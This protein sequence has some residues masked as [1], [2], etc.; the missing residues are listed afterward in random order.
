MAKSFHRNKWAALKRLA[1]D[2]AITARQAAEIYDCDYHT[3][4]EWAKE[5]GISMD[6]H[7]HPRVSFILAL[8]TRK[9]KRLIKELATL[10]REIRALE[11]KRPDEPYIPKKAGK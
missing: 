1:E 2:P 6:G 10:E 11:E 7:K 9:R 8:K 5:A 4:L 3:V